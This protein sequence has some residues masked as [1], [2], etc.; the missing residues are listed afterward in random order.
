MSASLRLARIS[1]SEFADNQCNFFRS[2]LYRQ[3]KGKEKLIARLK[4]EEEA[5]G[6]E[7]KRL[8]RLNSLAASVPY[9]GTIMKANSDIHKSTESRKRDVYQG[10][11]DL[12]DFQCGNLKSFTDEQLFRD[13]RF[14]L[15]NALHA[16]G[17]AH[18]EYA[19]DV[20]REAIPRCQERTTGIEPY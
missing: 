11:M 3:G 8:R 15:G 16:A 14:R 5:Q 6:E 4:A 10:R 20:M 13:S 1:H 19:R 9:Y 18:T 7:E 12:A 2:I 17:L